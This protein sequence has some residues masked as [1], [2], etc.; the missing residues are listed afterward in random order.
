MIE[1]VS[2]TQ[3]FFFNY[4]QEYGFKLKQDNSQTQQKPKQPQSDYF[5]VC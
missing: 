3:G 2:L 4:Q 1:S 5:W